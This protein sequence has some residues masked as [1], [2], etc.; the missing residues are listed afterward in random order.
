MRLHNFSTSA[1]IPRPKFDWPFRFLS[2]HRNTSIF[3]LSALGCRRGIIKQQLK[4]QCLCKIGDNIRTT[5]SDC[6][7][8]SFAAP[9]P[10]RAEPSCRRYIHPKSFPSCT[11]STLHRA[12]HL[13]TGIELVRNFHRRWFRARLLSRHGSSTPL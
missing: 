6:S 10:R 4:L 7:C 12:C 8:Q 11:Q 13:N 5:M 9:P 1:L 2:R 3:S